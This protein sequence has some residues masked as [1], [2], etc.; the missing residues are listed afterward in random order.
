MG[1]FV[2]PDNPLFD[3]KIQSPRWPVFMHALNSLSCCCLIITLYISGCAASGSHY[4]PVTDSA[5]RHSTLG[6]SIAPPPGNGWFERHQ[7]DSLYYLKKTKPQFYSIYTKAT[8][9]HI[10]KAFNLPKDFHE[11]V[12][13]QKGLQQLSNRY[14]N[15]EFRYADIND[16]SPFCVR[17]SNKFEDH[18]GEKANSQS[19]VRVKKT[20]IVCMHPESPQNGIDMYY[21]ERSLSSSTEPSSLKEGEQ[22]LSSLRFHPVVN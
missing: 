7:E 11:Y 4:Y 20:G 2:L 14:R 10:E 19:F 12:K 18:T 16:L 17:Y 6:F 8:E 9:V 3:L 22:F 1:L 5:P 21:M 13:R 15:I